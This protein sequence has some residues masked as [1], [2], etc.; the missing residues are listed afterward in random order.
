MR[1]RMSQ[2][3][4]FRTFLRDMQHG[5]KGRKRAE[6]HICPKWNK[7]AQVGD[8]HGERGV[9]ACGQMP[10][11][12]LLAHKKIHFIIGFRQYQLFAPQAPIRRVT[13]RLRPFP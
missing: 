5:Y 1:A 12:R 8:V 7:Q 3:L 10:N 9:G 2:L 13:D 6:C 11:P 4:S